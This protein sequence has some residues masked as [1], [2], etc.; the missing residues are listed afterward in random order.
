MK[1]EP[2]KSEIDYREAWKR[3]ELFFDAPT[4][5]LEGTE[6]E[7]LSRLIKNCKNEFYPIE[8]PSTK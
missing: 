1:S 6:A 4:S 2:I 5:S 8:P 7:N 3:M